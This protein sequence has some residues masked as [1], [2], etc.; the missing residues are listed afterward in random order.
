MKNQMNY[1]YSIRSSWRGRPETTAA[2][3]VK[4]IET[5]DALS[6][7]D[8]IFT[9]WEIVNIRDMSSSLSRY[10]A[11]ARRRNDRKQRCS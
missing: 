10:G 8:P 3:S 2:I 11:L 5:L 6:T 7:I 1:R 9:D 4:F